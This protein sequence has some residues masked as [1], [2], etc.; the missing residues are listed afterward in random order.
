ME[1]A[2]VVPSFWKACPLL[3]SP[4]PACQTTKDPGALCWHHGPSFSMAMTLALRVT[5]CMWL[6][7]RP[8]PP[9]RRLWKGLAPA[10]HLTWLY[11]PSP[12]C[13]SRALA[14]VCTPL[15]PPSALLLSLRSDLRHYLLT[16][17][18]CPAYNILFFPFCTSH[19][20]YRCIWLLT[21]CLPTHQRQKVPLYNRGCIYFVSAL[22]PGTLSIH[23]CWGMSPPSSRVPPAAQPVLGFLC[24]LLPSTWS[25]DTAAPPG[26]AQALLLG[27]SL[28]KGLGSWPKSP[29]PQ[30]TP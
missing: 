11:V 18:L 22:A 17:F 20:D 19:R 16:L 30:V 21:L 3:P 27:G 1:T 8:R 7:E 10:S 2:L 12:S 9:C 4:N 15:G 5:S 23:A 28:P 6:A 14:G 29:S 26:W 13:P 24:W 25:L